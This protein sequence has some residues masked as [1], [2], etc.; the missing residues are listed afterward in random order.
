MASHSEPT[1]YGTSCQWRSLSARAAARR[2][3]MIGASTGIIGL[4]VLGISFHSA[5]STVSTPSPNE[6]EMECFQSSNIDNVTNMMEL[7]KGLKWKLGG[8][9]T[10]D[11]F[12]A[13]NRFMLATGLA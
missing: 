10:T 5:K 13:P 1:A 12:I 9:K 11:S 7:I 8:K 6:A 4:V 2:K 3:R